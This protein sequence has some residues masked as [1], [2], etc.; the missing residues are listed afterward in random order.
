MSSLIFSNQ[1]W[2]YSTRLFSSSVL[3]LYWRNH[4]TWRYVYIRF[5]VHND[6]NSDSFIYLMC[7][8]S[9]FVYENKGIEARVC[10][11]VHV[12][13]VLFNSALWRYSETFWKV[14]ILYRIHN[15]Q[16]VGVT[17]NRPLCA[18]Y[19]PSFNVSRGRLWSQKLY[20]LYHNYAM[21]I[22]D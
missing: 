7:D 13:R 9:E 10:Q 5:C 17:C 16:A 14:G 12:A 8:M 11:W 3:L 4:A 2:V 22:Y 15:L 18:C 20:L 21:L 1:S 19:M 6:V